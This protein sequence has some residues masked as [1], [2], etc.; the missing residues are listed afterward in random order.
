MKD[1]STIGSHEKQ[2]K[3]RKHVPQLQDLFMWELQ[4]K[5]THTT[6]IKLIQNTNNQPDG[7]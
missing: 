2:E 6:I 4:K 1:I 3:V 7:K 5:K